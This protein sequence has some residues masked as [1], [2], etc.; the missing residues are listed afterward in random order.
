MSQQLDSG[1][2]VPGAVGVL[3]VGGMD[4]DAEQEA[5]GAD[6]NVALAPFDLFGCIVAAR[7]PSYE[8]SAVN[9]VS[10][11]TGIGFQ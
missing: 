4:E 2:P 6:C 1:Q 5:R 10:T 9:T 8:A 7:P 11:R 3:D